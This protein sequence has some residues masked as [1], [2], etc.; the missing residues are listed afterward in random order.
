MTSRCEA[1]DGLPLQLM[2]VFLCSQPFGP[3]QAFRRGPGK[4]CRL[5]DRARH[6]LLSGRM[7]HKALYPAQNSRPGSITRPGWVSPPPCPGAPR[8]AFPEAHRLPP[9]ILDPRLR[10][11]D[12]EVKCP[13]HATHLFLSCTLLLSSQAFQGPKTTN[14]RESGDSNNLSYRIGRRIY[15]ARRLSSTSAA[16]HDLINDW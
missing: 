15:R 8:S 6:R 2:H 16:S 7:A 11:D 10:G 4:G 13:L 12:A 1:G 5:S 3:T 14:P 9:I